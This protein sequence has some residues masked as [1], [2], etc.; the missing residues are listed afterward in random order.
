[1]DSGKTD[2]YFIVKMSLFIFEC[3]MALFYLA[4]SVV[5][6]FTPLLN[7]FSFLQGGFRIGFGIVLG[8]Y[9]LF[10]VYMAYKKITQR[11]E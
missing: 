2:K 4:A 8:L 6:L 10:R 1:M 11:N 9:G 7:R 3:M 5:L